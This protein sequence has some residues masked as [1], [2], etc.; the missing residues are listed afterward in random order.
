MTAFARIA[1]I[2]FAIAV[3]AFVAWRAGKDNPTW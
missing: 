3:V 1:S 2:A